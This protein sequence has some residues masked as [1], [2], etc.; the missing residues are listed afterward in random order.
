M[1]SFETQNVL[2]LMVCNLSLFV[3]VLLFLL[4]V[5]PVVSCLCCQFQK[6]FASFKVMKINPFSSYMY[7]DACMYWFLLVLCQKWNYWI[8]V[9]I[10]RALADASKESSSLC[11]NF[12]THQQYVGCSNYYTFSSTLFISGLYVIVSHSN[13]HT[14]FSSQTSTPYSHSSLLWASDLGSHALQ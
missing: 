4:M 8:I 13:C 1:T 14:L 10:H 6:S 12:Q 2:V 11:T 3:V 5:P 9:H 7:F